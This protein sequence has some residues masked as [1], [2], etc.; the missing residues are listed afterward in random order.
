MYC[1]STSRQEYWAEITKV[2]PQAYCKTTTVIRIASTARSTL[3]KV[4]EPTAPAAGIVVEM[5]SEVA[6]IELSV[7]QLLRM[8]GCTTRGWRQRL[9]R[10]LSINT[11]KRA[12]RF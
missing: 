7:S 12:A 1:R 11:E 8:K 4:A 10:S 6:D 3:S 2:R 5:G 9:D